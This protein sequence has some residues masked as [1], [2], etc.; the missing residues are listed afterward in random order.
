MLTG[1]T[2]LIA[3]EMLAASIWVGSLVCLALVAR[4]ARRELDGAS[5]VALFRGIGRLYGI[6]GTGALVAAIGIG[7]ALAWPL[8]QASDAVTVALVLSAILACLTGAAM[9]QARRMTVR[10]LRVL[11]APGD[12]AAAH[13]LRRGAAWAGALRGSMAILTLLIL[14]LGAHLL[15]R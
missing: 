1:R 12:P 4:V 10:R 15:D 9:V 14:V 8:T 11:A 5:R 3:I 7:V 6:V 2:V 13:A